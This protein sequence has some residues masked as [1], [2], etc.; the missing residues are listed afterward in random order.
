[1][2]D[3]AARKDAIERLSSA[4]VDLVG[5]GSESLADDIWPAC[6]NAGAEIRRSKPGAPPVA[7][8]QMN[9]ETLARHGGGSTR[10]DAFCAFLLG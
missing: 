2:V 7:R 9:L 6:A 8:T 3:E 10:F 1:V 4:I 5:T